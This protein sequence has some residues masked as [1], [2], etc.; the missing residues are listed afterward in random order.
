MNVYLQNKS[1]ESV[2]FKITNTC[3]IKLEYIYIYATLSCVA[4][5]LHGSRSKTESH[6]DVLPQFHPLH[7]SLI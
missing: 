2:R 7:V 1:K 3:N 6:L 4:S 5:L